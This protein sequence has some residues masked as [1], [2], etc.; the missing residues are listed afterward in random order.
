MFGDSNSSALKWSSAMSIGSKAIDY[1][2]KMLIKWINKLERSRDVSHQDNVESVKATLKFLQ[3]YATFHF[4]REEAVMTA[5]GFEDFERHQ[6]L[7]QAFNSEIKEAVEN[8][9]H[10]PTSDGVNEIFEFLKRWLTA[11]IA[12]EDTKLRELV[13]DRGEEINKILSNKIFQGFGDPHHST[14]WSQ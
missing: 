9:H 5:L 12:T 11:H 3:A 7:H 13:R 10:S 14:D 8:W 6:G 1:D 2:H 4:K